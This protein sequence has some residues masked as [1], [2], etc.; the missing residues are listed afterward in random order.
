MPNRIAVFAA[1]A[2][3]AACASAQRTLSY[4]ATWPDADVMVGAHRYQVW[5]H[6]TDPTVLIQRGEPRPLGQL[7]AQNVTVYAADRSE[8]EPVWRAAADAVLQ[9]IGC[10]AT[11][12]RGADQMREASY[13]CVAGVDVR[14]AVAA[15][16]E[17]WRQ[18][19]RVDDPTQVRATAPEW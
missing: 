11:E 2:A 8:A 16:R 3:L 9:Q 4:P 1:L 13:A 18:G 10:Q 19:V 6:E 15:A 12:V 17:R 5:F 14:S 7:L